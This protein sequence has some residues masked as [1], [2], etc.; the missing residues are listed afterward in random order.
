MLFTLFSNNILTRE[1]RVMNSSAIEKVV[2]TTIN[3][4][5]AYKVIAFCSDNA[6]NNNTYYNH[7]LRKL[8]VEY[9]NDPSL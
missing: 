4:K 5:I 2:T 3:L 8:K 6:S 7:F 1:Q 9:N